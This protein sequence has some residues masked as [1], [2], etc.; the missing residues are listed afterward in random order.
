MTVVTM[1]IRGDSD[2]GDQWTVLP[3]FSVGLE[4]ELK[5]FGVYRYEHSD[6]FAATFPSE[7]ETSPTSVC[8]EFGMTYE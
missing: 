6:G 1:V 7:F 4:P 5:Y 2:S 8:D 3:P